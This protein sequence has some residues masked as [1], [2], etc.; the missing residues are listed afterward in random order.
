MTTV[1]TGASGHVGANLIRALIDRNRPVRALV[2]EHSKSLEG[3]DIDI[4][5]R[6]DHTP[7][8]QW[9]MDKYS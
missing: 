5:G 8:D 9:L 6:S 7:A 1:V 4:N 3:L 2:H